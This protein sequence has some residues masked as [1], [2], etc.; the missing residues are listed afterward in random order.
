G[1]GV[2]LFTTLLVFTWYFAATLLLIFTGMLLG[3][4]LNALTG[5]LGRRLPLPHPVRLAIVCTALGLML[6]GVAYLGGATI[7]QQ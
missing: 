5:A 1:I 4:G 6:A 2:V 3:L 7:A